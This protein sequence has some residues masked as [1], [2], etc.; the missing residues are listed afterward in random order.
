[1]W[2]DGEGRG[3]IFDDS[4]NK[5]FLQGY[6][7]SSVSIYH[8]GNAKLETTSTGINVTGAPTANDLG[9][10]YYVTIGYVG[11]KTTVDTTTPSSPTKGDVWF[12][13]TAASATYE[14]L[15]AKLIRHTSSGYN[16]GSIVVSSSAPG[17]PSQG[18]IWFDIS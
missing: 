4:S 2:S 14:P 10:L 11:G 5:W 8:N 18:D 7:D 17:S 1:M 15:N 9:V 16:A 6:T 3:G 13:T 12:D